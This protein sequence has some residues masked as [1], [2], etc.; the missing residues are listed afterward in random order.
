MERDTSPGIL[1]IAII[2]LTA[3]DPSVSGYSYAMDEAAMEVRRI[4]G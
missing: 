1:E 3:Q 4:T 2:G